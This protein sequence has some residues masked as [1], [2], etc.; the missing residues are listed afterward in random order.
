[1]VTFQGG[2]IHRCAIFV[3]L[4]NTP[5]EPIHI[6]GNSGNHNREHRP[7]LV[8][9]G[10]VIADNGGKTPHYTP[11]PISTKFPIIHL[12]LVQFTF[13]LHYHTHLLSTISSTHPPFIYHTSIYININSYLI[14]FYI[15]ILS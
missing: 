9:A 2:K 10:V 6:F 8:V 13:K 1:M 7:T 5:I 15:I 4:I 14:H 11:L 3:G 12:D